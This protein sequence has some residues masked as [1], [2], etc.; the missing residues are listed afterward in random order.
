[1]ICLGQ[2]CFLLLQ[3]SVW[4]KVVS[5]I[6]FLE[7]LLSEVTWYNMGSGLWSELIRGNSAI[8]YVVLA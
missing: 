4:V 6:F 8:F 3:V 1:M 7:T 2:I 5:P